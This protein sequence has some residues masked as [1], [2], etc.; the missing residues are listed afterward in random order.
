MD[1]IWIGKTLKFKFLAFNQFRRQS[2]RSICGDSLQLH[3]GNGCPA[4]NQN[5]DNF[6][7]YITGGALTNPTSTTIHMAQAQGHFP[8]NTDELQCAHIHDPFAICADSAIT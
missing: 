4:Q 1:P 6:T 3:S 7:Y 2:R 5:P 8:S